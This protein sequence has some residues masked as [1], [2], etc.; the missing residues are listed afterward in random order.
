MT[1]VVCPCK[2]TVRLYNIWTV[3][4]V[5]VCIFIKQKK[6]GGFQYTMYLAIPVLV[7]EHSCKLTELFLERI[8]WYLNFDLTI[9]YYLM[10]CFIV[11]WCVGLS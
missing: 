1:I 10:N 7:G 2:H 11:I 5:M 9:K 6:N 3:S 8:E 4:S